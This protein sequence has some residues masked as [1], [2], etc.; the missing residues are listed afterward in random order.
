MLESLI[1]SFFPTSAN[2]WPSLGVN[3]DVPLYN[4]ASITLTSSSS[5][6]CV[7]H[8]PT[9]YHSVIKKIKKI[10][11]ERE[12]SKEKSPGWWKLLWM[13]LHV[14]KREVRYYSCSGSKREF[15]KGFRAPG[16]C[17]S[18]IFTAVWRL[19]R[20][21]LNKMLSYKGTEGKL[22]EM[23][24]A[25]YS[26]TSLFISIFSWNICCMLLQQKKALL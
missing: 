13:G 12:G 7:L 5:V 26:F 2:K 22:N 24:Q 18:V 4:F 25:N 17:T 8:N 21:I 9:H 23:L 20:A 11:K 16:D 15:K 3:G 14:A 1:L 6:D 19:Y 10:K